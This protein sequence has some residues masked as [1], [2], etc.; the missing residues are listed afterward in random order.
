MNG[1]LTIAFGGEYDRIA[2]ACMKHSRR[3]TDLPICVLTNLKAENRSGVWSEVSNVRFSYYPEL[4]PADNRQIKMDMYHAGPFDKTLYLDADALIQRPGVECIFDML[5]HA[6][7]VLNGPHIWRPGNQVP[8]IY[9]KAMLSCGAKLP[10]TA[11][12]GGFLAWNKNDK[13]ESVFRLWHE[14]WERAGEGRDMPALA[15]AVQRVKP[16]I[17]DVALSP[18]FAASEAKPQCIIQHNYNGTFFED[19]GLPKFQESKPFD[20]D[21]A[22]FRFTSFKRTI[23]IQSHNGIGDLLFVTPTLRRVKESYPDC[24]LIVNTNRPS[25]LLDNPYVDKINAGTDGVKLMYTAPDTGRLPTEHHILEDWRIVC[26]AHNLITDA[27]ELRP[28]LYLK[29]LP[30]PRDIIGVQVLHK[31]NYHSKRVW[32][33]FEELARLPGFEGIPKIT[34]GDEMVGIV[35]QVASYKVVVCA[36][37]GISHIAAALNIPAVVIFGGFSDPEWTGYPDHVNITSDIEC[38]HCYNNQPC[39]NKEPFKCFINIS[40][41]YVE[42]AARKLIDKN[43]SEPL[44]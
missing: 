28:E 10:I 4:Q 35:R 16:L 18:V 36:E 22:D 32:H 39:V 41:D 19:F 13:V 27:P 25:L 30:T 8:N 23:T 38:R 15:C 2:A 37:G 42:E 44:P 12:N 21:P 43:A 5:D 7:F 24:E 6:D 1:I 3:F 26:D 29:N 40:A 33:G 9:A 31:R 17:F 11:Y 20:S 34:E 14:Y